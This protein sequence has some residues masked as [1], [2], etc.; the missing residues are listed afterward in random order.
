[1]RRHIVL[2]GLTAMFLVGSVSA[3]TLPTGYVQEQLVAGPFGA[4]P[5]AFDFFPDGRFILAEQWSG[6]LRVAAAGAG[7]SVAIHTIADVQSGHPERGLLG[8]SLDPDWPTRPYV[9]AYFTATDSTSKLVMWEA[10]GD[11][12]DPASTAITLTNRYP[13]LDSVE[14]GRPEHNSGTIRFAPDGTLLLS[15][16][17]DARSCR[18]QNTTLPH[19]KILRLDVSA[20]PGVPPGAPTVAQVDPGDNPLPGA[21]GYEP[22][23]LAWGLRNPFRFCVD[24]PTGEIFIGDVGWNDFDEIDRIPGPPYPALNF[25]WPQIEGTLDLED[26]F[27]TCGN[28]NPFTAPIHTLPHALNPISVIGG[29]VLRSEATSVSLP[30]SLDGM[31]LFGELY[32][33]ELTLLEDT[34]GGWAAVNDLPGQPSPGLFGT[35]FHGISEFR[36]GEDG[37]VYLLCLGLGEGLLPRGIHRL[38]VDPAFTGAPATEPR[39]SGLRASP[40]PVRPQESVVLRYR[41]DTAGEAR[42]EVF[43]VRGRRLASFGDGHRGIGERTVYVDRD[44]LGGAGVRFVTVTTADG[45]SEHAKVT[46][47][48]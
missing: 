23:V 7:T 37:A 2:G 9:Y 4:S 17:D 42:V 45:R 12:T 18:A 26:F 43:D 34:G 16:G 22:L 6:T 15:I 3:A 10:T 25:G 19:G 5:V 35:D 1:M 13:I 31:F 44:R 8:V 30:P 39:R 40:N 20:M 41:S 33:G 27:G 14:D 28:G 38:R 21:L 36:L 47:L 11:L 29:V 46:R 24:E 32:S 48:R